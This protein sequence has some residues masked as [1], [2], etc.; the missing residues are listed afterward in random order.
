MADLNRN[1]VKAI[2]VKSLSSIADLPT[3][4]EA[5]TLKMLNDTEKKTF[6]NTLKAN[7]NASPYYLDDGST[8]HTMYYDVD[9]T[10]SSIAQL[11]K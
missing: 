7:L 11:K 2:V 6:L 5:A 1:Q 9:L 4:V 10:M 3:H 8:S